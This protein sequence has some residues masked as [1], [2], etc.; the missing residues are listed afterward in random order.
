[1]ATS[2]LV[3][4]APKSGAIGVFVDGDGDVKLTCGGEYD[5]D[6]CL[7]FTPEQAIGLAQEL[8]AAAFKALTPKPVSE[9]P[10]ADPAPAPKPAE[11]LL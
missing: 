2:K 10:T 7:Y 1:M 6:F 11:A 5:Y 4:Y 8:T 9:T 3:S